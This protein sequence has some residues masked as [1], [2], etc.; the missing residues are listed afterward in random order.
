MPPSLDMVVLKAGMPLPDA[1]TAA[2]VAMMVSQKPPIPFG[3]LNDHELVTYPAG[4]RMLIRIAAVNRVFFK[5]CHG[6]TTDVLLQ[7]DK[8]VW[9]RVADALKDLT[10]LLAYWLA[11]G[12]NWLALDADDIKDY[13]TPEVTA[14]MNDVDAEI[15]L[16]SV[17]F[18]QVADN[19][20]NVDHT[21][22][23]TT[24]VHELSKILE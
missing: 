22:A 6:T 24:E 21:S 7:I 13:Q 12:V 1:F 20:P 2:A 9:L 14:A 8:K 18:Y 16:R 15:R 4:L 23:A 11:W 5:D 3:I 19:Y 17:D 10:P